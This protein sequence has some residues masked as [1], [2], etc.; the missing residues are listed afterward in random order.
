M[1]NSVRMLAFIAC[2]FIPTY[3]MAA[4]DLTTFEEKVI[5][6]DVKGAESTFMSAS[7]VMAD[8]GLHYKMQREVN[9]VLSYFK[10]RAR[11]EN[12]ASEPRK[13]RQAIAAYPF[14]E[15]AFQRIPKD[16]HFSKKFIDFI[17]NSASG[18]QKRYEAISAKVKAADEYMAEEQRRIREEEEQ[19]EKDLEEKKQ[20]E[21]DAETARMEKLCGADYGEIRVGEKLSRVQE[22]FGEVYLHGQIQTKYG[23]VSSYTRGDVWLYVKKGKVVA[24]GD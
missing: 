13:E 20:A 21:I 8:P 18:S 19:R 23:V 17:Q 22:C 9:R 7:M 11:F 15:V 24:W 6:G 14:V 5:Q 4:L 3:C 1:I 10:E 2:V 12:V 16:L